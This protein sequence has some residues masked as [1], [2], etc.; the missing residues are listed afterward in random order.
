MRVIVPLAGPD[1]V[2]RDGS[3]KGL[4]LFKGEPLL[5]YILDSRPWALEI[6]GYAFVLHDCTEA[7][8]FATQH[9][10][11]WYPGCSIIYSTTFTR[12]AALSALAGLSAVDDIHQPLI[13]DLGDI[14]YA[15]NLDIRSSLCSSGEIGAI[16]LV[17]KSTE[18][19]YSYLSC[20]HNGV[21]LYA[22]EKRVVSDNASAGTYIFQNPA[23]FLRSVAFAFE[24]EADEAC[25]N[26][27]YVCPLFN[28]VLRQGKSV[29]LEPV[30][31]V[32]DVKLLDDP[33]D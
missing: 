24:N 32:S 22:A 4:T 15:S 26:L 6:T 29:A 11:L 21:F 17:F 10:E 13:I 25:N 19:H 16:A 14:Y 33:S 9:L 28:G 27:F 12:G 2:R 1:F 8:W 3:I 18:P 23:T 31:A 7:R 5:K 20:D 30:F